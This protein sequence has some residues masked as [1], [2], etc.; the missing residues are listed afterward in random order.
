M[1]HARVLLTFQPPAPLLGPSGART[2][3]LSCLNRQGVMVGSE[4]LGGERWESRM[5]GGGWGG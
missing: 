3:L 4:G 1:S 5:A 2:H